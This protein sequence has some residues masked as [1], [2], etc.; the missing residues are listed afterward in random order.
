MQQPWKSGPVLQNQKKFAVVKFATEGLSAVGIYFSPAFLAL[1][2]AITFIV[3]AVIFLVKK[4][5][6]MKISVP[7][8]ILKFIFT[9]YILAVV[10]VVLFPITIWVYDIPGINY[11]DVNVI[12]FKSIAE[13]FGN[14]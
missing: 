2:A 12:P 7:A 8:F 4:I 9:V 3:F 1:S 5:K 13:Q 11:V 14:L 10:S 6:H